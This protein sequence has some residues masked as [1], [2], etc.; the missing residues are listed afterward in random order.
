MTLIMSVRE[1]SPSSEPPWSK[2]QTRCTCLVTA[3][4]ITSARV[5]SAWHVTSSRGEV[6]CCCS[7]AA[8]EGIVD[9]FSVNS[10]TLDCSQVCIWGI[11]HSLKSVDENVPTSFLPF[12]CNCICKDEIW[13]QI[14][15]PDLDE[16]NGRLSRIKRFLVI[17]S[18]DHR[19]QSG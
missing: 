17:V 10:G 5:D 14:V 4:S 8:C 6:P 1:T 16:T 13:G 19:K 11:G 12:P 9:S 7:E 2:T 15:L 18:S 3:L